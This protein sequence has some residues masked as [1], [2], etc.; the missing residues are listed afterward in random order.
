MKNI[1]Q[2]ENS[3]QQVFEPP[4]SE[5]ID[6]KRIMGTVCNCFAV[7]IRKEPSKNSE[8]IFTVKA[9]NDV[10]LGSIEP[11]NG[12]YNVTEKYGFN[13]YVMSDYIEIKKDE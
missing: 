10:V 5:T 4:I 3:E 7:N 1:K 2:Y 13:G 8:V 9:G 12:W 6:D 11:V